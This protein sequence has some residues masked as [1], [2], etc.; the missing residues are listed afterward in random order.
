MNIGIGQLD[1]FFNQKL[2]T[3]LKTI[4]EQKDQ[5]GTQQ[6]EAEIA[7]VVKELEKKGFSK[8]KLLIHLKEV[9]GKENFVG[10]EYQGGKK[11]IKEVVKGLLGEKN[12][13]GDEFTGGWNEQQDTQS[14][15]KALTP[16]K[17]WEQTQKEIQEQTNKSIETKLGG[18]QNFQDG[19]YQSEKQTTNTVLKELK[20]NGLI[21]KEIH[22]IFGPQDF[23]PMEPS[24]GVP[25]GREG[26]RKDPEALALQEAEKQA[27]IKSIEAW[28]E[29]Y[30]DHGIVESNDK[31]FWS[32][33]YGSNVKAAT[34]VYQDALLKGEEIVGGDFTKLEENRI[35]K[36]PTPEKIQEVLKDIP[37]VRRKKAWE[38]FF[39]NHDTLGNIKEEW[40]DNWRKNSLSVEVAKL[41]YNNG[42]YN[43]PNGLINNDKV[44]ANYTTKVLVM[45]QEYEQSTTHIETL[46]HLGEEVDKVHEFIVKRIETEIN[47]D[48]FPSEEEIKSAYLEKRVPDTRSWTEIGKIRD[49]RIKSLFKQYFQGQNPTKLTDS[50]IELWR[51]GHTGLPN[52][53]KD[54]RIAYDNGWAT[55]SEIKEG[56]ITYQN[57]PNIEVLKIKKQ[58]IDQEIAKVDNLVEQIN[59]CKY[60]RDLDANQANID[61][62]FSELKTDL[63]PPNKAQEIKQAEE[64]QRQNLYYYLTDPKDGGLEEATLKK[65][66]SNLQ[67]TWNVP[68]Y[69]P[70]TV[71]KLNAFIA[72]NKDV[73]ALGIFQDNQK[74]EDLTQSGWLKQQ[75]GYE[76]PKDKTNA[77][78]KLDISQRGTHLLKFFYD[79][80][81][82]GKG[83]PFNPDKLTDRQVHFCQIGKK[84]VKRF[85][86]GGMMSKDKWVEEEIEVIGG[87][88]GTAG[89]L[90]IGTGVGKTTKL[91]NCLVCGGKRH[92]ILVCPTRGLADSAFKHHSNW[93]QP[94][95]CVFHGGAKGETEMVYVRRGTMERATEEDIKEDR[96][97]PEMKSLYKSHGSYPVA[98]ND[99]VYWQNANTEKLEG[100]EEGKKGLSVMYWGHLLGFAARNLFT[101]SGGINSWSDENLKQKVKEKQILKE[102]TIIVFDEAH[103]NDAGYQS[104]QFEMI[105]AG[106]NCLRMSATFPGVEFSATSTYQRKIM[107]GGCPLD[108]NMPAGLMKIENAE[109]AEKLETMRGLQPGTIKWKD[110]SGLPIFIEVNLEEMVQTGKGWI[111]GKNLE[112]SDE[113]RRALGNNVAYMN[114][115]PEFDENCEEITY[116]RPKGSADNVDKDKEMG[117]NP[118]LSWVLCLGVDETTNLQ[119]YFTF[120]EPTLGLTSKAPSIQRFGRVGRQSPGLVITL[121]KEFGEIDL[122]DNVSAAMVKA[123]FDGNTKQIEEKAYKQIYDIN[124][125]RGALSYPDPKTFGKAPEEILMG[126]KITDQQVDKKLPIDKLVWRQDTEEDRKEAMAIPGY[127]KLLAK[128]PGYGSILKEVNPSEKLWNRYLGKSE[129]ITMGEEQAKNLLKEMI[130]NFITQ[131]RKY[132]QGLDLKNQAKFI[133]SVFGAKLEAGKKEEVIKETRT[134]LNGLVEAKVNDLAAK[135]YDETN[136]RSKNPN[137]I[138]KLAGLY[139]LTNAEIDYGKEINGEGKLVWT[140]RMRA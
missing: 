130:S 122:S 72:A 135:D 80:C 100:M 11:Q 68:N 105:K 106:Y 17:T 103:F 112:L 40:K 75:G 4:N 24:E 18:P 33:K 113:Q 13:K 25:P 101:E 127:I 43:S 55:P 73:Q 51:V 2:E 97:D 38:N 86:K 30:E 76:I 92:V 41:I 93:L 15:Q 48:K 71:A 27:R 63:L 6:M 85:I 9:F 64:K 39:T 53:G 74:W 19:I 129:A 8:E 87:D 70:M 47:L 125:L 133:S 134:V 119:K 42:W 104:L 1:L 66:S 20:P 16:Y 95:G 137:T 83:Y 131:D 23:N 128:I 109:H 67:N 22:N 140:L 59:S 124:I 126:L 36:A 132:P 14:L 107:F 35:N 44:I 120:S 116:G 7:K 78:E 138:K 5:K 29:F 115:T 96:H 34:S 136:K 139:N 114:Y 57:I 65:L 58:D 110:E 26:M 56:K 32:N 77:E 54:Q 52:T 108:P 61:K 118:D 3:L 62:Q 21:L 98:K 46:K 117:Y 45:G 123:A 10:D 84:V 28:K 88:K 111:F 81:K 90:A 99:L 49:N 121:I 50:E 94:W 79:K 69:E 82:D 31:L 102:D 91:I 89:H 37:V 60:L 12:W